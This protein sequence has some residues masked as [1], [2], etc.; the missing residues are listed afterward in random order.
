MTTRASST[1][2]AQEEDSPKRP[3]QSKS[4]HNDWGGERPS[5]RAS[6]TV[7][8]ETPPREEPVEEPGEE[9]ELPVE[10]VKA[11]A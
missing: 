10:L 7:K 11:G 1:F 4:R 3:R 5:K 9:P 6:T 2:R 8:I